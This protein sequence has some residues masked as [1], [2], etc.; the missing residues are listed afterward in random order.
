MLTSM[1]L[2]IITFKKF[3]V[4]GQRRRLMACKLAFILSSPRRSCP[5]DSKS[6]SVLTFSFQLSSVQK[7]FLGCPR[8]FWN[9]LDWVTLIFDL[10]AFLRLLK[11]RKPSSIIAWSPIM[12]SHGGNNQKGFEE[13]EMARSMPRSKPPLRRVTTMLE[14]TCLLAMPSDP[15]E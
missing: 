3:T 8:S 1:T 2:R 12:Q 13:P 11:N 4:I 5:C 9:L 7:Q 10:Y 15:V 14:A 6:D